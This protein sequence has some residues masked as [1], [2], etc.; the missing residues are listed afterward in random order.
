MIVMLREEGT[1]ISPVENKRANEK[2][3]K[4]AEALNLSDK[5]DEM[6]KSKEKLVHKTLE[7]KLLIAE[8]DTR[9]A[10]KVASYPGR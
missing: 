1:R 3:K 7:T 5:V 6:M 4:L 9:E 2:F 8:K 10:N